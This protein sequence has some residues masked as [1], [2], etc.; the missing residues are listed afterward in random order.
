MSVGSVICYRLCRH[1]LIGPALYGWGRP[2]VVGR[3]PRLGPVVLAANHL[4]V[5]DSFYLTLAARRHVVF[6]AKREYFDRPGIGGLLR[7]A[8]FTAVGQIAVDRRGGAAASSALDAAIAT[9]EAGGAW[10]IHPE[11]SRSRDGDIHRGR[12]GAVRVAMATGAPLIPVAITGTARSGAAPWWRRRVVVEILEPFDLAPYRDG[13]AAGVRAATDALMA[14]IAARTGQR[15][16]DTYSTSW[17]PTA[18]DAA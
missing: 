5:V 1:L 3:V 17:Q 12:T 11:G 10:G 8:F 9:V 4:A 14:T 18:P 2:R 13:G 15:Y 16:V 6:L 7:R